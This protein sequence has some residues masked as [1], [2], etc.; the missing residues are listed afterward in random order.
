MQIINID[1]SHPIIR[2]LVE[3]TVEQMEDGGIDPTFDE[4]RDF[5]ADYPATA[6]LADFRA[7]GGAADDDQAD[8]IEEAV[9]AAAKDMLD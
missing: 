1:E 6:W 5:T 7:K 8:E 9:M 4:L 2:Q 3:T